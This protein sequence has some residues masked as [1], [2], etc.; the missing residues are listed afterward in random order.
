VEQQLIKAA[1]AGER[2]AQAELI[3]QLQDPWFRLC[4]GLLGNA[5]RARDAVQESALRFLRDLARFR[6]ESSLRTWAL[7]IAI[8]VSREMRRRRSWPT[9]E[10]AMEPAA[11]DGAVSD[12]LELLEES[13]KLRQMLA[14]LPERQR[15]ALILRFFEEMSVE[16]TARAMNAATG[17]IKATVHQAI[18]SL[19]KKWL[20]EGRKIGTTS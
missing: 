3:R 8:N 9:M 15:E 7:G 16:E 18:R 5:E 10:A 2:V 1:Q 19:R 4:L 14:A 20:G 11:D 17:T 13:G 6:F 12:R